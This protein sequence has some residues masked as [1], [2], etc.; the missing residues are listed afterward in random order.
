MEGCVTSKPGEN[1]R[2][3]PY[4]TEQKI[5]MVFIYAY[6]KELA[7]QSTNSSLFSLRFSFL[8]SSGDFFVTHL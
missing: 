3:K 6:S 1:G 7:T 2:D 5:C 4:R 8:H